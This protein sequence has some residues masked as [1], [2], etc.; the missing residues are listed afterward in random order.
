MKETTRS[1]SI[2][3]SDKIPAAIPS[4]WETTMG[5]PHDLERLGC[6]NCKLAADRFQ[7][8]IFLSVSF[9]SSFLILILFFF[10]FLFFYF[11]FYFFILFYFFF[12]F[13]FFLLP[14]LFVSLVFVPWLV[15]GFGA[16]CQTDGSGPL[17][18]PKRI[19]RKKHPHTSLSVCPTVMWDH[20]H[21]RICF[22]SMY[23]LSKHS[24]EEYVKG[25][26]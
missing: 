20:C 14:P 15:L 21:D 4:L 9:S 8:C 16:P 12:F 6:C 18:F 25:S 23:T 26:C 11:I 10:Y 13:S 17:D 7:R 24:G 19:L 5:F 1:H 22:M 3:D 2:S